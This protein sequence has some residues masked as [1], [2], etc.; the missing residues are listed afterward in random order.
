[1]SNT[2]RLMAALAPIFAAGE[3]EVDA[4]LRP[5]RIRRADLHMLVEGVAG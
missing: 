5:G 4:G 2:E 3:R 1:M